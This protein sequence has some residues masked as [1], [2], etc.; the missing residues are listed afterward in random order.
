MSKY[1]NPFSQ[2]NDVII[3]FAETTADLQAVV[4]LNAPFYGEINF[5]LEHEQMLWNRHPF[6][7]IT[8]WL[9]DRLIGETRIWP[10]PPLDAIH[11][12]AGQLS[13]T[14]VIPIP[15]QQTVEAGGWSHWYIGNLLLD[16]EYRALPKSSPLPWLL[17]AAIELWRDTN[18]VRFPAEVFT[19][20]YSSES[21]AMLR[22][23]GFMEVVPAGALPLLH[24]NAMFRRQADTM[25]DLIRPFA[26]RLP[27]QSAT[28]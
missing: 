23:F 24:G 8:L 1:R 22:R 15:Y 10:V 7:I 9:G 26:M 28:S 25:E 3:R 13:Y 16:P 17:A 5:P 4:D 14:K 27:I 20:G 19:S 21:D 11:Y 2:W 18:P 12:Q 6:G